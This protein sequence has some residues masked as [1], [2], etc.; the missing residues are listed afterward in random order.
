MEILVFPNC[1]PLTKTLPWGW[2]VEIGINSYMAI[3]T[4]LSNSPVIDWVYRVAE[5]RKILGVQILVW[6][7]KI[8]CTSSYSFTFS[9]KTLKKFFTVSDF[10][11][12]FYKLGKI[13]PHS[14]IIVIKRIYTQKLEAWKCILYY[15]PLLILWNWIS[16]EGTTGTD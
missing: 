2:I 15:L 12:V 6:L 1:V 7:H 14:V 11:C 13:I 10:H 8:P 9:F 5:Q 4:S 3:N 16:K